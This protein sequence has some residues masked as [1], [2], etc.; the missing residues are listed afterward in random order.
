MQFIFHAYFQAHDNQIIT[1][2]KDLGKLS[3]LSKL[4]LSHNRLTVLPEELG[5]LKRLVELKLCHNSLEEIPSCF[6]NL[7]SLRIMVWNFY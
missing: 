1:V 2:S 3:N 7:C 6:G 4:D 5:D